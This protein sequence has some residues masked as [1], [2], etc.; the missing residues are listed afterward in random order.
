RAVVVALLFSQFADAGT[1]IP[2]D[3]GIQ[4]SESRMHDGRAQ[5]EDDITEHQKTHDDQ[6]NQAD[7]RQAT[8]GT[9]HGGTKVRHRTFRQSEKPLLTLSSAATN[10]ACRTYGN[11]ILVPTSRLRRR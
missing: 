4:S 1:V 11:A 5:R 2:A 7:R 10:L 3:L 9:C 8:S 6:G